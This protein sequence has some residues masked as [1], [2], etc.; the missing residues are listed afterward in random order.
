MKA[1]TYSCFDMEILAKRNPNITLADHTA[2]ALFWLSRVIVW[3]TG[4]IKKLCS[5]YDL[6][7][8]A[9]ERSLFLT[10][11]F[12]DAGKA[13]MAFQEKIRGVERKESHALCSVPLLLHALKKYQRWSDAV[14]F[15]YPEVL[16]VATHHYRLKKN[17]FESLLT[18]KPEYLSDGLLAFYAMVN[19]L[20]NHQFNESWLELD[21]PIDLNIKPRNHLTD[22]IQQTEDFLAL[23]RNKDRELARD[24]FILFKGLLHYS[25]WLASAHPTS[26]FEHAYS[27]ATR[28]TQ[29]SL[30]DRIS[31]HLAEKSI[32]F[33]GWREFQLRMADEAGHLFVR[34][35][36][37]QGKTEGALLWALNG[38]NQKLLFLLPTQVTTDKIYKRLQLLFGDDVALSHG[39]AKH[40][41]K[42]YEDIE[43]ERLR[44]EYLY[45]RT[46]FKPITVATIDQLIYSFFNWGYWVMT[47]SAAYN[48]RI[49]IDE[50]H[51]YDGF[52]FGLILE[53]VKHCSVMNTQ[54][55]FMSASLPAFLQTKLQ[56]ALGE[57]PVVIQ[58]KSYDT[59]CR[60]QVEVVEKHIGSLLE[61]IAANYADG[62]KVL[63]VCNTKKQALSTYDNL[64]KEINRI[65][66]HSQFIL[67]DR[68]KKEEELEQIGRTDHTQPIVAVCTQVVEVSLDL[69]FDV[70]YTENAPIDC[71]I[72]RMGRVNRKGE[73]N[74]ARV[75]VCKESEV[76]RKHIYTESTIL[77]LTY[78]LL[79][80]YSSRLNGRLQEKDF[81][82]IIEAVYKPDNLSSVYFD[83]LAEGQDFFNHLWK[84]VTKFIFNLE[85]DDSQLEKVSSRDNSYV[86][87]E[88]LLQQHNLMHNFEKH[89]ADHN[90]DFLKP[91]MVKVPLWVTKDNKYLIKRIGDGQ[92][93]VLDLAYTY[94]RGVDFAAPDIEVRMM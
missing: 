62:K 36:T 21:V 9:L 18:Y 60:H 72:Q 45:S 35:P 86:Q 41:L 37:G 10:V 29:K 56:N 70:L 73:K 77:D 52:T 13:T 74:I 2:D 26:R 28:S 55:A 5:C 44:T 89:F 1:I 67:K 50:I 27:Y 69:D 51:I 31:D 65:L 6:E 93:P 54:F 84:N 48:A 80:E 38:R 23:A 64:P 24:T 58:D 34:I 16:A 19:E 82:E 32:V 30:R 46:F 22:V 88:C 8:K 11:A 90:F 92:I 40:V 4:H 57:Q 71:L 87:V 33:K 83:R 14:G 59:L 25:D 81:S 49:V 39:N 66:Y 47:N 17:L 94:D 61:E 68:K 85:A 53:L 3:K 43:P 7:R 12:H 79:V 20:G 63:V 78:S 91:F 42:E 15:Y 76:S 75:V